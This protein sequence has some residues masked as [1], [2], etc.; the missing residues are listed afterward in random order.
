MKF[1]NFED[2]PIM[3]SVNDVKDILGV[4]RAHIYNIFHSEGFPT[5]KIGN[6]LIVSK[7]SL[8][9]WLEEKEQENK[10]TV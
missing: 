4:S 5:V 2:L 7:E 9:R 8:K 1:T 6:R 3:L 10:K